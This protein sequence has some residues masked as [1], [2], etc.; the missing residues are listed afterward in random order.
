MNRHY[1]K[2]IVKIFTEPSFLNGV[3]QIAIGGGYNPNIHGNRRNSAHALELPL[4]KKP[5]QL[6]LQFLRDIADLVEKNR[7]AMGQ[8]YLTGL[9]PVRA[10]KRPLFM[11]EQFALQ[12]F[13][14]QT[15]RVDSDKG[16][17]FSFTPV[18]NGP[19]K[20]FFAGSA[21]AEE[22]DRCTAAAAFFARSTASFISAL[23]PTIKRWRSSTSSER[24]S[25]P[26]LSLCR[27]SAFRTTVRRSGS[28]GMDTTG[29]DLTSRLPPK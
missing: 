11:A 22:Q 2:T 29:I 12:E 1:V 19:S 8:F 23:S 9:T 18:V 15:H 16:P 17:I 26:R 28:N 20:D 27:S 5:Q 7:A 14:R 4:L 13:L 6:G 25:T 10:G 3:L 21:F 24:I